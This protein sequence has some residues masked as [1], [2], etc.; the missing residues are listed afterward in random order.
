MINTIWISTAPRTGS[1]WTF[2][3]TRDIF[4]L[5]KR[6]VEPEDVPQLDDEMLELA[7]QHSFESEDPERIW[8]LKCHKLMRPDLPKSKVITTH[9][10]PRDVLVSFKDFMKTSYEHSLAI[11]RAVVQFTDVY[12]Q[13]DPDYLLMVPYADIESQPVDVVRR[14]ADFVGIR[15]SEADAKTSPAD[16]HGRASRAW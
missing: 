12:E 6:K 15:I 5:A 14:I 1:M 16:F 11:A 13:Y 10:D 7:I 2:N 9:R 8:V 4:R 3:I